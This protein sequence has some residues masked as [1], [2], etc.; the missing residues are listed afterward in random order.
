VADLDLWQEAAAAG[1]SREDAL[2]M[3]TLEGAR[4]LNWDDEIGSLEVGKQA[5]IAVLTGHPPNRLSVLTLLA[6]RPVH[7]TDA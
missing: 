6:G 5:D 7:Q 1:L 3:L 4:A 2:R